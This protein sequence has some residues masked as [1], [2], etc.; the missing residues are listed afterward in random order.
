MRSRK[1]IVAHRGA[2]SAPG[3]TLAA[4]EAAIR[5]GADM[6]EFDV[7]RTG[8]DELVVLHDETLGGQSVATLPFVEVLRLG[9][10]PGHHVPRLVELLD[11]V[12]GRTRL[13]V[14]LKEGGYEGRVLDMIFSRGVRPADFVVTSFEIGVIKSVKHARPDVRAGLLVDEV[15]PERALEMFGESGA[16]F[17][18]PDCQIIDDGMLERAGAAAVDLL[19]WTVNE[20][21]D[22]RRLLHAPAVIGVIT[23]CTPEAL[24]IR[25]AVPGGIR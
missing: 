2:G 14:E 22:I 23:D 4:F 10:P 12:R 15:T 5:L 11:A 18:G 7:R 8:D 9:S 13:D 20:P 6:I 16:D 21:A 3:N 1:L 17:L 19:P 25:D 24:Q